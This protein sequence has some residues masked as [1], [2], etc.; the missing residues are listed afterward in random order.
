MR[1]YYK[2]EG[3]H[4]N[5]LMLDLSLSLYDG[6]VDKRRA[7]DIF[8]QDLKNNAKSGYLYCHD[9]DLNQFDYLKY[10]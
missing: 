9:F 1:K 5:L 4:G 6:A 2:E 7:L 8:K 3:A 10:R